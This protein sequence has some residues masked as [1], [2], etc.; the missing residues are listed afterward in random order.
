MGLTEQNG[1][2][3][4]VDDSDI[5]RH[6]LKNF[7]EDY[8]FQVVTC[9]DGLEGIQKAIKHKPRV[10]FLDLLM[11]NLNG[12]KML[13]V[14]KVMDE[15]KDIPVIVIS[16]NA[17]KTNVLAAIEAGAERVISKPLKKTI[18]IRNVNE[19]L[20]EEFLQNAKKKTS[21]AMKITRN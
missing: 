14:I 15:L 6:S 17:N 5:I 8:K 12:L 7:F 18:I 4:I 19:V 1:C 21:L 13:Q 20:G 11:P 2:V 9:N 16:G 3:L 10:I